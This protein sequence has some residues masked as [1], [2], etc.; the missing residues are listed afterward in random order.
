MVVQVVPNIYVK[1]FDSTTPFFHEYDDYVNFQKN[2]YINLRNDVK[3]K[4]V[5]RTGS[6]YEYR[7]NSSLISDYDIGEYEK[8]IWKDID[9]NIILENRQK[10]IENSIKDSMVVI[11]THLSST[12]LLECLT[13]KIPFLI[14]ANLKKQIP[15]LELKKEL[16][17]LEKKILCSGIHK[18]L[19]NL[20]IQ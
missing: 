14:L 12:V 13:F 20:L 4:V 7:S 5:V 1:Y 19:L 6:P 17:N 3:K 9:K 10:P 2:F 8:R 11:I 18:N 16:K 15:S